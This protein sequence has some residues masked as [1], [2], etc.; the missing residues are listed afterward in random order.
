VS[1]AEQDPRLQLEVLAAAGVPAE[2]V[3][4]DHAS[5]TRQDWPAL[6]EVLNLLGRGTS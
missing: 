4:V 2:N 3:Y 5:G 6:A 1:T